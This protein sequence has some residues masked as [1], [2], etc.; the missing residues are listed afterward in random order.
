M[1]NAV[2]EA[3]TESA[4]AEL[5]ES[6]EESEC[7]SLILSP[8]AFFDSRRS[9]H[10]LPIVP[11]QI[12]QKPGSRGALHNSCRRNSAHFRWEAF[13]DWVARL[14]EQMRRGK[15]YCGAYHARRR[16]RWWVGTGLEQTL[17]CPSPLAEPAERISRN[18]LPRLHSLEGSQTV[19]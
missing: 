7:H 13:R 11:R 8:S 15:K 2:A 18:G 6:E 4:N 10:E 5:P 16:F 12:S 14:Y 17:L 3:Q 1:L 19:G 9:I